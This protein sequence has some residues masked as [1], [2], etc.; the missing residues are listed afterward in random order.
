[1]QT[2]LP[3]ADFVRTAAVLDSKRLG[4]QRV[5]TLQILQVLLGLRWNRSGAEAFIEVYAAK[6]W[7]NHPAVLGW[8]GFEGGLVDYQRVICEEWVGR[9]FA[10]TCLASSTA[11]LEASGLPREAIRPAWTYDPAVHRSHQSNL[12][13]KDP[14]FYGPLFPGVPDDL[15]YVWPT[16]MDQA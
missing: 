3:Y 15:D 9:G 16:G 13:R 11:L 10:D 12:I 4:K 14:V 7:R 6:A 8:K 2:F 5:E 1:M